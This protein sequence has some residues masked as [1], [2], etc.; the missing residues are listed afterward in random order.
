MSRSYKKRPFSGIT[1][2]ETEKKDKQA[3][4]RVL[5]AHFRCAL[6]EA[7][8]TGEDDIVFDE[9]NRAHS[10]YY[11]FAKDGKQWLKV[12]VVRKG[13]AMRVLAYPWYAQTARDVYR[14]LA[15]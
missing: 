14:I 1:T 4:H 2:S 13:R 15:K 7:R 6:G 8:S 5:R 9:R 12:R 11:S 10:N 3:A